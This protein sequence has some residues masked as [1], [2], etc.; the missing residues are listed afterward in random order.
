MDRSSNQEVLES[1]LAKLRESLESFQTLSDEL[2]DASK[3]RLAPVIQRMILD[4]MR[5]SLDDQAG[6]DEEEVS[7]DE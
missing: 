7:G 1:A 4:A 5:K 2:S 6:P 3:Q